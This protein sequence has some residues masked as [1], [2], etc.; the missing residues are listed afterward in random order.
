VD[1]ELWL[2]DRLVTR[3]PL[4]SGSTYI[5][6]LERDPRA[7]I[8]QPAST[9][10]FYLPRVALNEFADQNDIS[11]ISD[12]ACTPGVG[13]DD[14]VMAHVSH[15]L[16]EAF[17]RP[18]ATTGLFLDQILHAVCAHTLSQ[19]G[20]A[21]LVTA[22]DVRGLAPWQ[23]RRAKELMDQR[24]DITLSQ[25]AESCQLSVT[26]FVRAFRRST[27]LSPHQWLIRRRVKKAM[28]LLTD[29]N[30]SIADIALAC[31]F[32]S[33]SHLNRAFAA[34]AGAPPGRWRRLHRRASPD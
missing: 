34:Q 11:P 21:R 9:L 17:R 23:E 25:I 10:H 31:G 2:D 29:E 30:L 28:A 15:A 6:D 1:H 3:A 24:L 20:N 26:H 22:R 12:L 4:R 27:G 18:H 5:Y 33:Q 14:L 8:F 16:V 7:R 13:A 19:Y 32:S